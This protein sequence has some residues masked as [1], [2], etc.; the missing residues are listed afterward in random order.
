MRV[1]VREIVERVGAKTRSGVG[2]RVGVMKRALCISHHL[3]INQY[4]WY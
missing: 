4:E 2:V 1:G 3:T